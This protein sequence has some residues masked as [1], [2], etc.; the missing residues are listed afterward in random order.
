MTPTLTQQRLPFTNQSSDLSSNQSVTDLSDDLP[1]DLSADLPADLSADLPTDLSVDLPSASQ[2]AQL[3]RSTRLG[4]ITVHRASALD[5][6][7]H[8]PTPPGESGR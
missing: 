6:T 2:A 3:G 4:S 5:T 7:P 1:T 8:T